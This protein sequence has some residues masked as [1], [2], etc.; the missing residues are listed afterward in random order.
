MS[1]LVIGGLLPLDARVAPVLRL[2]FV[3]RY[4]LSVSESVV[5]PSQCVL[6]LIE[7]R[8]LLAKPTLSLEC[9]FVPA[10]VLEGISSDSKVPASTE[11]SASP[12]EPPKPAGILV[13][14]LCHA[15][16]VAALCVF[17][18]VTADDDVAHGLDLFF[19]CIVPIS[20]LIFSL[21]LSQLLKLLFDLL[22]VGGLGAVSC[23][24]AMTR[25]VN[26]AEQLCLQI[27]RIPPVL[28][29]LKW[30]VA[31]HSFFVEPDYFLQQVVELVGHD[32]DLAEVA[33]KP[34]ELFG[35]SQG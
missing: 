11:P 3:P 24:W 12:S 23:I 20:L 6:R 9:P 13:A 28:V 31:P 16:V 1:P 14:D 17:F 27:L 35:A 4:V 19:G 21:L 8:L 18:V 10:P 2:H 32:C 5:Q 33:N 29:V 30:L 25:T 22:S 15:V 26:V 34:Q 7:P